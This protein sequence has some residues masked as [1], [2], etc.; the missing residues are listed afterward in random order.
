MITDNNGNIWYNII[1]AWY[2]AFRAYLSIF[3][4]LIRRDQQR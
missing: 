3:N 4:N 2:D 1:T